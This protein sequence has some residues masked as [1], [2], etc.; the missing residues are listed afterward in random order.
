MKMHWTIRVM[1]GVLLLAM[2]AGAPLAQAQVAGVT[3][4]IVEEGIELIFKQGGKETAEELSKLGGRAAVRQTLQKAANE[5]GESLV[6]RTTAYG[7]EQGPIALR[8]IGRSPAKMVGALD[9]VAAEL[10]PA[11]LRAVEREP[12]ALTGLVER[13]GGDA[14]EAAAKQP[15][16]GTVL[17]E[18]LG[19]EG[20]QAAKTLSTDQSIIV[21]RHADEIAKL[22]AAER[23]GFF[24]KLKSNA[25]GVTGYLERHPKT[26]LTAAG[27]AVVLG[28]KDE[29]LGPGEETVGPDGK[30]IGRREGLVLRVWHDVLGVLA[31][32]IGWIAT[33][34]V[35]VAAIWAG[36][37]VWVMWRR[38][39]LQVAMA[40]VRGR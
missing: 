26:L 35:G 12:T 23:A 1:F 37:K 27:V 34:L 18:K 3:R 11:A 14:L 21:A 9:N 19:S 32:P 15:G 17:G 25:A 16:V 5:G 39:R 30:V 31:K 4:G 22:P 28:A 8:A 29:I 24:A 13:F 40:E 38:G 36:L 20:L 6:L 33:L 10:R 7:I 2:A